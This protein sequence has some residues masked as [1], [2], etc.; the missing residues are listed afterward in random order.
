MTSQPWRW[1]AA[2]CRTISTMCAR[3]S[4]RVPPVSTLVP[5]LTTMRLYMNDPW[6][7]MREVFGGERWATLSGAIVLESRSLGQTVVRLNGY[8]PKTLLFRPCGNLC[9]R[10]ESELGED[11]ADVGIH[12]ALAQDQGNGDVVVGL[13]LR[14]QR[15][16]LS[17]A[18]GQPAVIFLRRLK[19]SA[20]LGLDRR[21][22]KRHGQRLR[23]G[24]GVGDPL[25]KRHAAACGPGS[26]KY[27]ISE[28]GPR[29]AVI[30]RSRSAEG[31][32]APMALNRPST[33][34]Q[35][36]G[37]VATAAS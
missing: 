24:Q 34:P 13:T 6:A 19:R 7:G 31:R 11:I 5:S 30:R 17:L 14:D 26:L 22:S 9:T 35:S 8:T 21:R 12:G 16:Y 33:I 18:P 1:S 4:R 3:S 36:T 2:H 29:S 10:R 27:G 28:P 15:R 23:C 25:L 20:R 37:A 32:L